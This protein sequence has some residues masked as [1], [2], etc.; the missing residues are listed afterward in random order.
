MARS[1]IGHW[2]R[3]HQTTDTVASVPRAGRPPRIGPAQAPVLQAQLEAY[4]EATL[5]EHCARWEAEQ[6]VRVGVPTLWRV[7]RQLGLTAPT[8]STR[9]SIDRRRAVPAVAAIH[10]PLTMVPAPLT[11]AHRG[12]EPATRS[13]YAALTVS[14]VVLHPG[15]THALRRFTQWL[16]TS[17]GPEVAG[18]GSRTGEGV[19][20]MD[21]HRFD[22]LSV[23]VAQHTSR[24]TVLGRLLGGGL[25]ALL[26]TL[27]IA[28]PDQDAAQ[29]KR[30]HHKH[31]H[32][33]CGKKRALS[34]DKHG[35]KHCKKKGQG[36]G[37]GGGG[38]GGGG[39]GGGSCTTN[40]QCPSPQICISGRCTGGNACTTNGECSNGQTCVAGTCVGGGACRADNQ[41]TTNQIC[42]SGVCVGGNTCGTNA[43]CTASQICVANICLGGNACTTNAQ[44]SQG[45]TC[46]LGTCIGG[47][48][49]TTNAQCINGQSCVLSVCVGV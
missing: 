6:G 33:K 17:G 45:Q 8:R 31:K 18:S 29:A 43:D 21:R 3:R 14:S 20:R 9:R 1:T 16:V 44:C 49:C 24:R 37:N 27:G 12:A 47:G 2:Y 35:R 15:M 46:V 7:I 41:C 34:I 4:P 22:A 25:A 48:S 5:A 10:A 30:H 32:K 23:A 19:S 40:G 28:R 39:N 36:G 38:G 42:V 11:G 26:V 13:V